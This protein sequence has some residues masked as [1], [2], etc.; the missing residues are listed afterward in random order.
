MGLIGNERFTCLTLFTKPIQQP[1]RERIAPEE[2]SEE[3][4]LHPAFRAGDDISRHIPSPQIE[5]TLLKY[6]DYL[7][8]YVDYL[9]KYVDYLQREADYLLKYVDYLLKYVDYLLK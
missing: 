2:R 1:R 5:I 6:V 8:K 7:L 9:L 3:Y 4:L